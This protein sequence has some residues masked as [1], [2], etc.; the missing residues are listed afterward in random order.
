MYMDGRW[1]YDHEYFQ[2]M[3]ERDIR[4]NTKVVG[5]VITGMSGLNKDEASSALCC[6][7]KSTGGENVDHCSTLRC[8]HGK[9]SGGTEFVIKM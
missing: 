5:C 4:M 3:I 2:Q 6:Y 1:E 7:T 8:S 9:I